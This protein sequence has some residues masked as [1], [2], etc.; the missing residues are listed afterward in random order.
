MIFR[1][2]VPSGSSTASTRPFGPWQM[3]WQEV[4]YCVFV[5]HLEV[6]H[7]V[8]WSLSHICPIGV[9]YTLGAIATLTLHCPTHWY[10]TQVQQQQWQHSR[11]RLEAMQIKRKRRLHKF[12][13]FAGCSCDITIYDTSIEE[14]KNPHVSMQMAT[15]FDTCFLI[16][17]D[18]PFQVDPAVL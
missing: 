8:L 14:I 18:L 6:C 10:K 1:P 17:L 11:S 15:I 3:E 16:S 5:D 7:F 4:M 13:S 12:Q 9:W 2:R